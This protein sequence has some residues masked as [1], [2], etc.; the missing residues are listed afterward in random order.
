M[1]RIY[2]LVIY[3][4]VIFERKMCDRHSICYPT[5]REKIIDTTEYDVIGRKI[6][7]KMRDV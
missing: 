4:Y 5:L 7:T 3:Y 6:E 2:F 1:T